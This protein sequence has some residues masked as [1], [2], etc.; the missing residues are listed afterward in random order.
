VG[1]VAI[2]GGGVIAATKPSSGVGFC[3][4]R[5]AR[6]DPCDEMLA[7]CETSHGRAGA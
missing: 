2:V 5:R 1:F 4:T 6:I 7:V 3:R